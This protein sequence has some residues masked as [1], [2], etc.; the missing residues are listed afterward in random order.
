MRWHLDYANKVFEAA[1]RRI[2]SLSM[3]S[4]LDSFITRGRVEDWTEGA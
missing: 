1:G 4:E 3:P 2:L